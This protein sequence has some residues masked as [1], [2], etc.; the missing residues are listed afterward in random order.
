MNSNSPIP[1]QESCGCWIAASSICGSLQGILRPCR[2][3]RHEEYN[4]TPVP[5]H[6]PSPEDDFSRI[7]PNY[8]HQIPLLDFLD[9]ETARVPDTHMFLARVVWHASSYIVFRVKPSM[10]VYR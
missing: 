8:F 7:E 10:E 1:V 2:R 4:E 6:A 5:P 9:S 3:E